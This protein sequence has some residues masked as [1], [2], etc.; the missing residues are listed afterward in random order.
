[1]LIEAGTCIC[2]IE[3]YNVPVMEVLD[4]NETNSIFSITEIEDKKLVEIKRK[5]Q[6]TDY[7]EFANALTEFLD[8][9]QD[10]LAIEGDTLGCTDV[11]EHHINLENDTPVIYIP[12]YRLTQ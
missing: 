2:D 4:T 7:P 11:I 6:A 3:S 12:A 1:M 8:Q 9:Y 5:S 10:V